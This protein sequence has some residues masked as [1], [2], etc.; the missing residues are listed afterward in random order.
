MGI[1]V[2]R[3]VPGDAAAV[4]ALLMAAFAVF[5]PLYTP[6]CFDATVLDE[7]RVRRRMAEGPV[8]GAWDGDRLVGTVSAMQDDRGIYVRGMG[9]HP[10]ARRG[11]VGRRLLEAVERHA[12]DGGAP[13]L[14]LSTTPFLTGSIALY[15]SFGFMPAQ[16]PPDLHG[17]PLVSFEKRLD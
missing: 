4:H 11:G 7:A 13:A 12:R 9:V 8:F 16:G 6:G 14:W 17:T 5:R 3:A 10:D 2:R 1:V 15:R